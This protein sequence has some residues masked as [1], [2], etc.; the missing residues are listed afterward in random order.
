MGNTNNRIVRH[1]RAGI[2]LRS[3]L[4]GG[5]AVVG[6]S[7]GSE[8]GISPVAFE[9][10][11]TSSQGTGSWQLMAQDPIVCQEYQ[12]GSPLQATPEPRSLTRTADP[13]AA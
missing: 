10:Q 2:L 4:I 5:F 9:I 8:A 7:A 13:H 6:F 12:F 1:R 3:V 11:A